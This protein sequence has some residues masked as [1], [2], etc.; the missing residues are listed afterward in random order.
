[1]A[2]ARRY[3]VVTIAAFFSVMPFLFPIYCAEFFLIF[4]VPLIWFS[5]KQRYDFTFN[6]G[7]LWGLVFFTIFFWDVYLYILYY[8]SGSSRYN[9]LGILIFYN[10]FLSGCWFYLSN[11]LSR[12]YS[13]YIIGW[14]LS[15]SIFSLFIEHYYFIPLG[16]LQGNTFFHVCIP[17]AIR[18]LWLFLL[19]FLGKNLILLLVM[20]I[21]GCFAYSLIYEKY[22]FLFCIISILIFFFGAFTYFY[23]KEHPKA[24]FKDFGCACVVTSPESPVLAAEQIA[25]ALETFE[26]Q[27]ADITNILMPESTFR[28]PLNALKK[29]SSLWNV[30]SKKKIF[31]GS[32]REQNFTLFNTLYCIENGKI[33]DFYD[34]KYT[35][36]FTEYI[37]EFWS[38]FTTTHLFLE[39][40]VPFSKGEKDDLAIYFPKIGM[41]EPLICSDLFFRPVGLSHG[42]C[43]IC[44]VNDSWFF[45]RYPARLMFL[46]AKATAV[47]KQSFI[48]YCAYNFTDIICPSGDSY[49]M[50][51]VR[52]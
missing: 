6:E 19:N 9:A 24:W 37:P 52:I 36:F 1:M 16:V 11:L 17:L 12:A 43:Y 38:Y 13:S 33:I 51:I 21:N 44:I 18:P 29:Y 28:F 47:L 22:R 27:Y 45:H 15:T 48:I 46:Y 31:L 10:T 3:S 14:L 50:P 2:F 32:H 35:M 7:C 23:S 5:Q 34:K 25:Y 8:G 39:N 4:L 42:R 41:V 20:G 40:K 30:S 49:P 26:E